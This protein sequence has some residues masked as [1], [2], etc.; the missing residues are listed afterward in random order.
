MF[1]SFPELQGHVF[2]VAPRNCLLTK[3]CTCAFVV[4]YCL[5][6]TISHQTSF[7]YASYSIVSHLAFVVF[8]I[9]ELIF[10]LHS[11]PFFPRWHP[12]HFCSVHSSRPHHHRGHAGQQRHRPS[13]EHVPGALPVPTLG[14]LPGGRVSGAFGA[15]RRCFHL[16]HSAR[17]GCSAGENL[18]C[19][20]FCRFARRALLPV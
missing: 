12:Q 1:L 18:E 15:C 19:Q 5:F 6:A 9:R 7:R 3:A 13:P 8:C 2:K 14:Q 11:F 10:F 4:L 17:P 20:L 16:Q